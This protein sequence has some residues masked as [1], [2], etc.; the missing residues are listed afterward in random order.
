[1]LAIQ[2][3]PIPLDVKRYILAGVF[4]ARRHRKRRSLSSGL[5]A[6]Q[7]RM[8]RGTYLSSSIFFLRLPAYL[9]STVFLPMRLAIFFR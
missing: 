6:A 3:H 1:M 9:R 7:M 4:A 5:H 2:M 8:G